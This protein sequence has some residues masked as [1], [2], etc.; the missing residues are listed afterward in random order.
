M[1][2]GRDEILLIANNF[3]P[4][5]GGSAVVYGALAREAAPQVSVLA[6]RISYTDGLPL[7]GWREH[8]RLAA[9]PRDGR[10]GYRVTRLALLR[11][12]IDGPR[13]GGFGRLRF[14]ARDLVIRWQMIGAVRAALRSGRIGAVCIGELVPSGWL[15]G[16]LRFW[17][18]LR[19]VVYIH[20]EEI[21]TRDDYDA[22]WA[23]R[24]STLAAADCIIVVSRFTADAV[25]R[26]LEDVAAPPILLIENGVDFRRFANRAD[27]ADLIAQYGLEGAFVFVSVCRLLEK[28]GIDH[29]I[30]AF[31]LL[32][33][34][35]PEC[36]FLVVGTG[37][38][39]GT[40]AAIAHEMGVGEAVVFA[41]AVADVDLA[42]H[43]A[44]GDVFVMPNR[45]LPSGD[46]EGFG[47]V[48]LEAN[49]AGVPVIAGR[50]GGSVD[51][52]SDGVNGLV[53]DGH[54]IGAIEAA[55]RRLY[56]NPQLRIDLAR[57][58]L[59]CAAAADWRLKARDF[60]AACLDRPPHEA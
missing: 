18:G 42:D 30:R 17:P 43:Y 60:V 33:R 53:V 7:I 14:I 40:L 20:G 54:A 35:H 58:G 57:R 45:A 1:T 19:R 24:R 3:P 31:A 16:V 51:A 12:P 11:T 4:V 47:L 23:R 27:R 46:T 25:R 6:P 48:F 44:L 36:R 32:W 38:Y 10:A 29:A 2:G 52:V 8:D 28:K 59:A 37:P 41:G 49:A 55:M 5:Q 15:F 13:R 26:L 50:D 39:A 21:T 22:D 34:D 9:R 56:D